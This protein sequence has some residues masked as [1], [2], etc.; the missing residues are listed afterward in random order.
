MM[1][2]MMMMMELG[3]FSYLGT[4]LLV[5]TVLYCTYVLQSEPVPDATARSRFTD[6]TDKTDKTDRSR[7][8]QVLQV[9]VPVPVPV[10]VTCY[11][12]LSSQSRSPS[13]AMQNSRRF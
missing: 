6:K 12:Y 13:Y 1:M 3:S 2:M 10:P 8:D 7:L 5:T 11:L 4:Y 9:P